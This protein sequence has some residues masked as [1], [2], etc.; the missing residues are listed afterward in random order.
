V[1]VYLNGSIMPA[2]QAAVSPFDRGFL[3]GDGVYEG[4][5]AFGG[6]VRDVGGHVERMSD[7]L[8]RASIGWDAGQ[9]PELTARLLDVN[10]LSDAFIYWQVTR[11]TPNPGDPE[12]TRLPESPLTPTVFGYARPAPSLDECSEPRTLSASTTTDRRWREGSLKSI[13][14]LGNILSALEA[15]AQGAD[16]AILIRDGRVT[17]S[18]S[19]NIILVHRIDGK[20]TITTPSINSAPILGGVTRRCI[21][22]LCPEIEERPVSADELATASEIMLIG[23]LTMITSVTSLDGNPVGDGKAGPETRRILSTYL[24]AIRTDQLSAV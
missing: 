12:R 17:E 7:G 10:K 13:S 20:T 18:T 11:G 15:E 9:L 5:R 4:L 22:R 19:S 14:L 1:Q 24:D 16:D 21:L 6:R 8:R 23:T 2:A 3:F